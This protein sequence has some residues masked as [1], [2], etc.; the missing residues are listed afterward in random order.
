MRPLAA[1]FVLLIACGPAPPG[2]VGPAAPTAA[3]SPV[4]E[5]TPAKAP[6]PC[7]SA[8]VRED[9]SRF[10][11]A[12]GLAE[13]S[14]VSGPVWFGPRQVGPGW[15]LRYTTWDHPLVP[16]EDAVALWVAPDP[17]PPGPVPLLI[18][19]QGH[20]GAGSES[21]EELR[22]AELFAQEGWAVLLVVNR[23][24]ER[25]DE[26]VPG[27]RTVHGAHGLYGE[28][29]VRQGGTT[30]LAWDVAAARSALAHARAG[31]FRMT[32]DTDRIAVF[33]V[34]GGSERAVALAAVELG[35]R[36]VVL[37]AAEYAFSTDEGHAGCTCGALRGAEEIV[38]GERHAARWLALS[39]CRPVD[40]PEFRPVLVWDNQPADGM[41]GPLRRLGGP[42]EIRPSPAHGLSSDQVLESW[43]FLERVILGRER[44]AAEVARVA[45]ELDENYVA[46]DPRGRPTRPPT[47][48]GPGRYEQGPPP[49]RVDSVQPIARL[50]EALHLE[51]AQADPAP[52]AWSSL[53]P[54]E[55]LL[56]GPAVGPNTHRRA[57]IVLSAPVP[58]AGAADPSR[59]LQ[60]SSSPGSSEET[61]A[62]L[63]NRV[64]ADDL[65]AVVPPR[66]GLHWDDDLF[67]ARL[68][69]ASGIPALAF[70]VADGLAAH[71]GL[72][73]RGDVD[74][75]RIGWIG[76]GAGGPPMMAAAAIVGEGG[77]VLLLHAPVTL[78]FD[79]PGQDHADGHRGKPRWEQDSFHPWPGTLLVPW[80]GG[81]VADP[82]QLAHTLGDRIRWFD[83]R[84]GDA[85]EWTANLP[86]GRVVA[87]ETALFQDSAP[88]SPSRP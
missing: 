72:R 57:W 20:F 66:V 73:A 37:G 18:G 17:P 61:V 59:G 29:R 83:P 70:P 10:L 60:F 82:W 74:P 49:W 41:E 24:D 21:D 63:R 56:D 16:G 38:D 32:I 27:W 58:Q 44:A 3:P 47:T 14:A 9:R 53:P 78:W 52:A 35:V 2:A 62:W 50:R 51:A 54:P 81:E 55:P 80:R 12:L 75:A 6:S 36:A 76:L 8:A 28:M 23:G 67:R 71:T 7:A 39:A 88:S 69:V 77:P 15:V 43:V 11:A 33:G 86:W 4:P 26:T 87:S 22:K 30:P 42:V 40:P 5:R 45:K 1:T 19:A 13:G 85:G 46:V 84:G 79:G 64:G 48:P 25:G 65:I 31:D 68:G 34:S